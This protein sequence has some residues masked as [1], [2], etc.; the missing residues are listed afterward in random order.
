MSILRS[1]RRRWIYGE[2][3][4]PARALPVST[5]SAC[6]ASTDGRCAAGTVAQVR[7]LA[8]AAPRRW[9]GC[10]SFDLASHPELKLA[11]RIGTGHRYN[12]SN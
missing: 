8:P 6:M 3:P 10:S 2:Q 7:Q 12:G 9:P 11:R 4:D 1:Q 5:R